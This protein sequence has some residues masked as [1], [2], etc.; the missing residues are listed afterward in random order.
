M[1]HWPLARAPPE[2]RFVTF[3]EPQLAVR[4]LSDLIGMVPYLLGFH[5]EESLV[6]IALEQGRI[7]VTA[8][9]DLA[10]VATQ[11]TLDPLLGRLFLRFPAAEGWFFA[12]TDD[13]ELAWQVL[14][15]CVESVG[16]G[17][18]GRIVQVGA[19]RWWGDCPDGPGGPLGTRI[20]VAAVEAAVR[21]L[22]ARAGRSE[23]PEICAGPPAGELADLEE[24]YRAQAE[25][26]Q[27]RSS[28]ARRRL[29][30][31][32]LNRRER[33][34][35]IECV[36]LAAL[37][38]D[39]AEQIDAL[40]TLSSRNA[41]ARLQR[42]ADVLRHCPPLGRVEVLGLLGMTAWQS[43]DGALQLVC[44]EEITKLTP[45]S[46]L[47]AILEWL[48]EYIVAPWEW[49]E[50]RAPLLSALAAAATAVDRRP[51]RPHR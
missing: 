50:L 17:R 45:N 13:R 51:S 48:N 27:Q 34:S 6:V 29:Q 23:L 18:L 49:P 46:E 8:R 16:F 43:G 26:L 2:A 44:V 37:V 11:D 33:L 41:A 39:P 38:G 20:S 3:P 47:A 42:W 25:D 5:P 31:R 9:V 19:E 4:S 1:D 36:Q 35:I 30:R 32:L 15:G 24:A 14:T 22:P 40:R 28:L 7:Q 12:F 21:G 10:A